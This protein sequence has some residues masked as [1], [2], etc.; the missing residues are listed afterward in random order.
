[1]KR[2]GTGIILPNGS[3]GPVI[4]QDQNQPRIS[5][6]G[7]VGIFVGARQLYPDVEPTEEK[8]IE[9]LS[10]LERD[11]VIETCA[12]I[13]RIVSGYS[14]LSHFERQNKVV[15]LILGQTEIDR[16]NAFARQREDPRKLTIF[17][18]GQLFY[19]I[20]RT[21]IY[22]IKN[23]NGAPRLGSEEFNHRFVMAATIASE[24][25]GEATYK[26]PFLDAAQEDKK[27]KALSSVHAGIDGASTAEHLVVTLGRS[28]A[29]FRDFF[30][31]EFPDF[32]NRFTAYA[33]MRFEQYS[34]YA[35][36]LAY[37]LNSGGAAGPV[38]QANSVFENATDTELGA[39]FLELESQSVDQ[40]AEVV[41]NGGWLRALRDRPILKLGNGNSVILDPRIYLEM[42]S[43]G[44]LFRILS[45]ERRNSNTEI[46]S[47]YGNAFE[48]LSQ[49]ALLRMYPH[50]ELL[51]DR[52]KA[53]VT[54]KD[55]Q[56]R[57]YEID[58]V[59]FDAQ[60]AL[61]FEMKASWLPDEKLDMDNPATWVGAV[62]DK[63]AN[64]TPGTRPLGIAQ[65]ARHVRMIAERSCGDQQRLFDDINEIHPILLVHDTHL[66][67]P[68]YGKLINDKFQE[69]VGEIKGIRVHPVTII[70][71]AD[72]EYIEC[73]VENFSLRG[74]L[75][76]FS[77]DCPDR[78]ESLR[79]YMLKTKYLNMLV[80]NEY[81][82]N[83]AGDV[84]RA[85]AAMF[86]KM[87]PVS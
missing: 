81:L 79:D 12:S 67:A 47:A 65:L 72:L 51:I 16:L 84:L 52:F 29:M 56:G 8:L 38:F 55:S 57:N 49:A 17:F 75:H 28:W 77:K 4:Q 42:L 54:G 73:S 1:M 63:Y 48:R 2:S 15:G 11:A 87:V 60:T 19:L 58:G 7:N 5:K 6:V 26:S 82:Y 14:T 32:Q 22:C 40:L 37:Y 20:K 62:L 39:R 9:I 31:K 71:Q 41:R 70:T 64:N 33:G 45:T 43:V 68:I 50:R 27:C 21:L 36:G 46:F 24:L 53:N 30:P 23:G 25:W 3:R 74:L 59:V 34:S 80:S 66:G 76:D 83:N 61:L 10:G 18:R 44:P 86:K 78:V 85:A 69:F 13:N 35:C